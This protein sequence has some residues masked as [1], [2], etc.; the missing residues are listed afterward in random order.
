MPENER[1]RFGYGCSV[2]IFTLLCTVFVIETARSLWMAYEHPASLAPVVAVTST[3]TAV[4]STATPP[5]RGSGFSFAFLREA[6]AL[7]LFSTWVS[8]LN[9]A[10]NSANRLMASLDCGFTGFLLTIQ[11]ARQPLSR[12]SNAQ[13]EKQRIERRSARLW[14]GR[15]SSVARGGCRWPTLE[16]A[17]SSSARDATR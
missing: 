8:R 9:R 5:P 3:A 17:H 15:C 2:V 16:A 14:E 10:R 7:R 12:S 1:S 13:N 6:I 11:S 4:T